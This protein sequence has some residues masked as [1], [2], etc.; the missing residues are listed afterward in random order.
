[1]PIWVTEDGEVIVV[2]SVAELKERA[3]N[4]EK[5]EDLH[6]PYVD[7]IE[8]KTDSGKIAKRIPEVFDCGLNQDP[9]HMPKTITRLKI[10]NNGKLLIRLI[11]LPKQ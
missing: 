8:I 3:I 6:R 4:P 7:D 1:M 10:K 11:L 2:G 5:V 9:C